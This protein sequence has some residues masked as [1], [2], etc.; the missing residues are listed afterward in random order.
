M[1][2]KTWKIVLLSII[3]FLVVP[4]SLYLIVCIPN[5]WGMGFIKPEDTGAWLG[6]Y[7]AVLGG[8][9]TLGGVVITIKNQKE[10]TNR[11]KL[12]EYKPILALYN[13]A[14]LYERT[15]F[16][17]VYECIIKPDQKNDVID[18]SLNFKLGIINNNPNPCNIDS[19]K[20]KNILHKIDVINANTYDISNTYSNSR[21]PIVMNFK[22]SFPRLIDKEILDKITDGEGVLRFD[23]EI[24]FS[25]LLDQKCSYKKEIHME[26]TLCIEKNDS[27]SI[28][29]TTDTIIEITDLESIK[30]ETH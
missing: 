20:I 21:Q 2:I 12:L 11:L 26:T 13:D 22:I 23:L 19:I 24:T 7:G 17:T 30:K 15:S 9:L 14:D 3:I 28:F 5:P 4:V 27:I 18:H 6:F 10:E 1:K 16:H 8:I 25:N 29:K